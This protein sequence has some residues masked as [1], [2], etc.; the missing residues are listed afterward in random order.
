MIKCCKSGIALSRS[1][2]VTS[3]K[4]V[5]GAERQDFI[6]SRRENPCEWNGVLVGGVHRRLLREWALQVSN[7]QMRLCWLAMDP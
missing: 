1:P 6:A 5:A 2:W 7:V 4:A 3:A